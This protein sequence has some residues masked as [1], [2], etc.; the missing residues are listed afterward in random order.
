MDGSPHSYLYSPLQT[1]VITPDEGV[2]EGNE[3]ASPQPAND[4]T[5]ELYLAGAVTGAVLHSHSL[6]QEP[7]DGMSQTASHTASGGYAKSR[8]N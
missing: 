5:G 2:E 8:V 3:A 7:F 4:D 1:C 6:G